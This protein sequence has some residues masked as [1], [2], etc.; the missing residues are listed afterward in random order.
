[1]SLALTPAGLYHRFRVQNDG[2]RG[3]FSARRL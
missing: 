3:I 1:M 2:V